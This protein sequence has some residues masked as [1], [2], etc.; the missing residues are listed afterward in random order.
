M[1]CGLIA[2]LFLYNSY[3]MY[4]YSYI[5]IAYNANILYH[6]QYTPRKSI[7]HYL[8]SS[9]YF[10][11]TVVCTYIPHVLSS[12]V[13]PYNVSITG[14]NMYPQGEQIVLN[15]YSQGGPQLQYNWIFL[16]KEIANTQILIVN[17]SDGG[18]YTCNVTNSAGYESYTI[19]IYSEFA[20]IMCSYV[21]SN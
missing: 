10:C 14:N 3:I 19:T 16:G 9:N 6:I 5:Q 15:C 8:F 7:L 12:L 11:V 13:A 1:N 4:S 2:N 20:I 18:N 17:V 21:I